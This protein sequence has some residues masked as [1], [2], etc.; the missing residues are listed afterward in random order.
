MN[1]E[2]KRFSYTHLSYV[3]LELQPASSDIVNYQSEHFIWYEVWAS[4]V[5]FDDEGM[6]EGIHRIIIGLCK[7]NIVEEKN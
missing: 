5:W 4:G 6:I 1:S 2:L 7:I 3:T